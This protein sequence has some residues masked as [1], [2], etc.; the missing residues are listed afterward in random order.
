METPAKLNVKN[1]AY[2]KFSIKLLQ[3]LKNRFHKNP[4]DTRALKIK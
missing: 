4:S 2:M 1:E 3:E